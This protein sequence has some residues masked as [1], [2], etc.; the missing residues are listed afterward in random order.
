MEWSNENNGVTIAITG[1]NG[2]IKQICKHNVHVLQM[3]C[4]IRRF[5]LHLVPLYNASFRGYC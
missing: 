2:G 5:T 1:Y 4:N 3:I